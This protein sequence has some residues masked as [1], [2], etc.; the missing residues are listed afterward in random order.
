MY[1]QIILPLLQLLLVPLF[2]V[3]PFLPLVILIFLVTELVWWKKVEMN[4]FRIVLRIVIGLFI[5]ALYVFQIIQG[6]LIF[7]PVAYFIT[8]HGMLLFVPPLANNICLALLGAYLTFE[9]I[10]GIIMKRKG[11][12]STSGEVRFRR[13]LVILLLYAFSSILLFTIYAYGGFS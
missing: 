6:E 1:T 5:F 13:V 3:L 4:M 9:G 8:G 2:F 11:V 7:S 12:G 10:R